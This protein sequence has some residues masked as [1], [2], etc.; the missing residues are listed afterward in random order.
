MLAGH[1][2]GVNSVAFSP[3]GLWLVSAG[4]DRKVKLWDVKKLQEQKEFLGHTD[5]VFSA[6]FFPDGQTIVSG[7]RDN[8][9]RIW[10]VRT[11]QAKFTLLGHRAAVE[12]VAVSPD[13]KT[14]A[15]ASWDQTIKLWDADTGKEKATLAGSDSSVYA[16][17]FS[18]VDGNLL[19]SATAAGTISLWDVKSQTLIRAL[20]KQPLPA[21]GASVLSLLASPS[22]Q[23][24]FLAASALLVERPRFHRSSVYA[25]A[26]SPDG[27]TL[28]SG[29]TDATAKLWDVASVRK[30]PIPKETATLSAAGPPRYP[31]HALA[32]APD[33]KVVAMAVD[34]QTVQ[35]RDARSGD[36]LFVLAGHTDVVTCLAFSPDSQMLATGSKDKTLRMWDRST[37]KEKWTVKCPDGVHALAF[38][39]DGKKLAGSGDKT[40]RLWAPLSGK[41][42]VRSTGTRAP[43]APWPS[44]RTA[45]SWP[46]AARIE[47]SRYGTWPAERRNPSRSRG[48]K[49]RFAPW[50]FPLR[51]SWPA[52]GKTPV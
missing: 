37:G 13:G 35:V 3:D 8:T 21:L 2:N 31:V 28:A 40:I 5:M 42:Q 29:S 15:T 44:L 49:G 12:T 32:Y 41:E 24:P 34:R 45:R 11:G 9:A 19:A 7:G 52:P 38:T 16:V 33:G 46:A 30:A 50:P 23:G 17:A 39:P 51:A 25:L 27:K 6:A 47:R 43:S 48:T 10:D 18:P 36:V 14:V 1:T 4:L 22:T 20:E 26:F